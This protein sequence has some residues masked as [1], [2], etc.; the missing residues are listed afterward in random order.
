MPNII[1]S[2]GFMEQ[3]ARARAEGVV[4]NGLRLVEAGRERARTIEQAEA[5]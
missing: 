4:T 5:T 3:K 2:K 1:K